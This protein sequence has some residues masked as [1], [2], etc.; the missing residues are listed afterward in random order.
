MTTD[1]Y[2]PKADKHG[3]Y[4][5]MQAFIQESP[6]SS[7]EAI[8]YNVV[9]GDGDDVEKHTLMRYKESGTWYVKDYDNDV[10]KEIMSVID[11]IENE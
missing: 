6:T 1:I 8:G 3:T 5:T 4:T 9:L 11:K 10:R 2:L 7:K